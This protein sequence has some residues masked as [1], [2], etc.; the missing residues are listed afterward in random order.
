MCGGMPANSRRMQSFEDMGY[1]SDGEGYNQ[2][3]NQAGGM[4]AAPPTA[5]PANAG[6]RY[7]NN[8]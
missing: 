7:A 8:P 4:G 3:Y 5:P 1:K 2:G 6:Y